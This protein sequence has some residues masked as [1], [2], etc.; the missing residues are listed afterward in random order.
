M[1]SRS[2]GESRGTG[3]AE[4][5]SRQA[6]LGLAIPPSRGLSYLLV[7]SWRRDSRTV[8]ALAFEPGSNR[9]SFVAKIGVGTG[10][11]AVRVETRNLEQLGRSSHPVFRAS[12]PALLHHAEEPGVAVLFETTARGR[13]LRVPR[14]RGALSQV[15][16]RVVDWLLLFHRE[17]SRGHEPLRGDRIEALVRGP[18]EQ[19]LG[20]FRPGP[21]ERDLLDRTLRDAEALAR[22]NLPLVGHHGDLCPANLFL[23]GDLLEVIDWETPL[24]PRLPTHDLIHLLA[25]LGGAAG[26][27]EDD[28]AW[29]Q[30]S[31]FGRGLLAEMSRDALLRY[32]RSMGIPFEALRPLFTLYWI[33]Y[34]LE[35]K[36]ATESMEGGAA[37]RGLDAWRLARFADGTCVNLR[38]LA[39]ESKG[40]FLPRAWIG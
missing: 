31:F 36:E 29:Y 18:V 10:S 37:S 9:P 19:Y 5:L 32:A 17:T 8:T 26:E 7:N 2:E 24:D 25:C 4:M 34:A 35:K 20:K 14:G 38:T 30:E 11:A 1:T 27:A 33:Q 40:F 13:R 3:I 23:D 21:A 15:V 16:G 22:A 6:R 39:E 28:F 12:V